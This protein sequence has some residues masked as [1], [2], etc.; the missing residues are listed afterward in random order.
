[1][2]HHPAPPSLEVVRKS[3]RKHDLR[4]TAARIAVMRQMLAASSPLSHAEVA[5]AL[6]SAGFDRATVYRNLVELSDAGL[7]SRV[8]LGDHVWRFELRIEG[9]SG[10]GEHP[11][12][13]CTQC[14]K[15]SCL[16]DVTVKISP[17]PG[18][19]TSTMASVAT[20]LLKGRCQAC[21]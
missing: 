10:D 18:S 2:T 6:A 16:N 17:T 4:C 20:V 13:V 3:L 1:M 5:E 7:L 12:F 9:G 14:G 21:A 15:I 8:E 19:Q 11:H